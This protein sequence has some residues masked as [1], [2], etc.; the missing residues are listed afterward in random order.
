MRPGFTY[1]WAGTSPRTSLPDQWAGT[2]PRN[3]STL[4]PPLTR[5]LRPDLENQDPVARDSRTSY[6]HQCA[7]TNS[8]P[9]CPHQSVGTSP[10]I[11]WAPAPLISW[12]TPALEPRGPVAYY[13]RSSPSTM[14]QTQDPR[15]LGLAPP[16]SRPTS[17]PRHLGL[18]SHLA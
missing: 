14:T 1:H 3:T 17:A 15:P 18:C 7:T 12:Q 4:I 16:Q 10:S 11:S 8:E 6:M 13:V 9:N 5:R 2:S